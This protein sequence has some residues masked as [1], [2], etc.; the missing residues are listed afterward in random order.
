MAPAIAA[1]Q[2]PTGLRYGRSIFG[3][4]RRSMMNAV[5]C[6]KYEITAPNTAM[7]SSAPT[8]LPASAFWLCPRK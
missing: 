1:P 2:T 6:M 5:H 4:L 3:N 7:Y 8:I